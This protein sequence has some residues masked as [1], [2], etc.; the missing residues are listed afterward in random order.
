MF[1]DFLYMEH[2]EEGAA[3]LHEVIKYGQNIEKKS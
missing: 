2:A 3:K 1:D